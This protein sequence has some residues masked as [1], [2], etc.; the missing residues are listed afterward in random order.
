MAENK[1]IKWKSA[2]KMVKPAV[3]ISTWP[4]NSCCHIWFPFSICYSAQKLIAEKN[5]LDTDMEG[6]GPQIKPTYHNITLQ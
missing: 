1:G 2:Y 4:W 6:S 3:P 5:V